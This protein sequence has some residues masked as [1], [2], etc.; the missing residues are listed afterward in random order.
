[1]PTAVDPDMRRDTPMSRTNPSVEAR[2]AFRPIP[3][4][5]VNVGEGATLSP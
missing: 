3:A 2:T 4:N 5:S 1:M